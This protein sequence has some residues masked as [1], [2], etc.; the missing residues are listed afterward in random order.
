M[1]L[2]ID[3]GPCCMNTATGASY[4]CHNKRSNASSV[5]DRNPYR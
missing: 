2:F 4:S 5:Y 3:G 1:H